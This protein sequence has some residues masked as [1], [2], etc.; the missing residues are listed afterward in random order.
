MGAAGRLWGLSAEVSQTLLDAGYPSADS[1]DSVLLLR[2]SFSCLAPLSRMQTLIPKLAERHVTS[3]RPRTS[4]KLRPRPGP[5]R[6]SPR[7]C[8]L[9]PFTNVSAIRTAPRPLRLSCA[10]FASRPAFRP[11]STWLQRLSPLKSQDPP[12]DPSDCH[13]DASKAALWENA[14]KG[15]QP[16]DLMLR[17]ECFITHSARP[18]SLTLPGSRRHDIGFRRSVTS[19]RS[20]VSEIPLVRYS[21]LVFRTIFAG[22]STSRLCECLSFCTLSIID[23][24]P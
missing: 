15:R 19:P 4:S 10:P 21:I 16:A 7:T 12:E 3:P 13:E 8:L 20:S 2:F 23:S 5:P 17:C 9:A 14:M 1:V 11:F 24:L 6:S 18:R 22:V